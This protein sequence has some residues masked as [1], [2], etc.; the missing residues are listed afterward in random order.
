MGKLAGRTALITGGS[1]GIG[2]A[3]A[4]RF[5]AEGADIAINY[6][7]SKG[8][9]DEV[10]AAV[11]ALGRRAAVYQADVADQQ[12]C[13]AMCSAAIDEFGQIDILVNNAGIGSSAVGRPTVNEASI[14]QWQLLLG[15]NLWGPIYMTG[16]LIPHMR[17]ADRADI[18]MISSIAAQSMGPRMGLYSVGKA[19]MEA[20]AHTLAKEEVAHGI[21]VNI[22]APGL[23]DTDMGRKLVSLLPGTDDMREL[24]ANMP[25][26]FVCTPEDI[27]AT[28]AHLC[29]PDGRYI[30][31][32]RITVSGGT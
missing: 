18:I 2:R 13:E 25:F 16:A 15:A 17:A 28:V 29:S 3:I 31:D 7:S 32:Q 10:A 21:R 22:V 9:A 4:L 6:A 19:G 14:E 12:A 8:A 1:R 23:V 20:L 27:A 11:T 5:A 24:D 30:T 26:G